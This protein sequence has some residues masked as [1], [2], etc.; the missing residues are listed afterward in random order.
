MT[1][2]DDYWMKQNGAIYH[3]TCALHHFNTSSKTIRTNLLDSFPHSEEIIVINQQIFVVQKYSMG[4]SIFFPFWY[5]VRFSCCFKSWYT[6]TC[7]YSSPP[8]FTYILYHGMVLKSYINPQYIQ[9]Y[10][11]WHLNEVVDS[12]HHLCTVPHCCKL[13]KFPSF[14]L[15]NWSSNLYSGHVYS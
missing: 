3:H 6:L 4:S 8:T 7:M 5:E 15:L 10:K 13:V 9:T 1:K 11:W 2:P 12:S 14:F